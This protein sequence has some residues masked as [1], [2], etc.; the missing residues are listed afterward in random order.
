MKKLTIRNWPVLF[1]TAITV[2]AFGLR[3]GG[4]NYYMYQDETY[5]LYAALKIGNLDFNY[6]FS[7]IYIPIMFFLYSFYFVIGFLLGIFSSTSDF[8][9]AYFSNPHNFFLIGRIYECIAGA[10]CIPVSYL[11]GVKLFNRR[12]GLM[13]ALFLS[14]SYVHVSICQ[15]ARGE[16]FSCLFLLLAFYFICKIIKKADFRNYIMVGIFSGMAISIRMNMFPI[17]LTLILVHLNCTGKTINFWRKIVRLKFILALLFVPILFVLSNPAISE[18]IQFVRAILK[19]FINPTAVYIGSQ[20]TQ[21]AYLYY[22]QWGF[23]NAFGWTLSLLSLAGIL[24]AVIKIKDRHNWIILSFVIPYFAVIGKSS[25][26]SSRYLFPLSP[27]LAIMCSQIIFRA[28]SLTIPK[29]LRNMIIA[30]VSLVIILEGAVLI[31][32]KN[33]LQTLPRTQN[34]SKE[35]VFANIPTGSRIAVDSMGGYGPDLNNVP[36]IDDWIYNLSPDELKF[37]YNERMKNNFRGG[38]ALKC[39]IENPPYPRYFLE[40]L[41][42]R[43]M[44]AIEEIKEQK[45]EYIIVSS[46]VQNLYESQKIRQ[47]FPGFASARLALYNWLD[48]D[49]EVI[50]IFEPQPDVSIGPIIKV[51]QKKKL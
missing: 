20:P 39:F 25:I 34:I 8:L 3:I 22:L 13:A 6:N 23:R 7:G 21:P 19:T 44:V 47:N 27:F 51:F 12:I 31:Y 29:R 1:L 46:T 26:A 2:V 43:E 32:D 50:K 10:A 14:F 42:T 16:A 49:W 24:Y 36:V 28:S 33:K 4:I 41:G 48:N 30:L 9:Q 45:I 35:W 5:W 37:L 18:Q 40:N 38:Y 15:R 17:I 11:I